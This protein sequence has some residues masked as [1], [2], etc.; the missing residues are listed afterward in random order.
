MIEHLTQNQ[1]EDYCLQ[2]LLPA[3]LLSVCDH[4]G[5]C[6]ACRRRIE[7]AINADA[8][9]FAL[10]SQVLGEAPEIAAPAFARLHPTAE[11]TAR[12]IEGSLAGEELQ[13][14]ADHLS[15]CDKCA[16]AVDDL[17]VFR[18]QIAFS[19]EREYLPASD[20]AP[21]E[22]W[23]RRMIA[24]LGTAFRG[25]PGLAF[26]AA[27]TVLLLAVTGWLIWR[28]LRDREQKQ[29]IIVTPTPSPSPTLPQLPEQPAP[30]PLVARLNDGEA[31]L[32]LDGEGKLSG[33]DDLPPAYQSLIKEALKSR[34]I[35]RSSELR[36]LNRPPSSLMG[37]DKERNE[38]SLIEPVGKVLTTDR[39]TFNWSQMEGATGYVVEIY[40]SRFNLVATS[41]QLAN[42]SWAMP[43]SLARDNVYTWQVKAIK[44]G[45]EF[46][47]PRPPAPQARF[48][49]LGQAKTIELAQAKRA[50]GSSHLTLGLLYADAGLIKEAEH[51]FRLLQKA[52]PDSEIARSL[53]SQVQALGR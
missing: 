13:T 51:E 6:D 9:F 46:T 48:R 49:I 4:L 35:V 5:E 24:S 30:A 3:D 2:K 22:G 29:E 28:T 36:G 25:S 10:R 50:Y 33:A 38:F 53:L 7:S 37:T 8:A 12:Y 41:L 20:H 16:M 23:W 21:T 47:S 14:V 27:L 26:G 44:D 45:H 39:P 15:G 18:E 52:N 19:L 17:R 32:T 1:V 34:R 31:Q 11:Q 43:Q 42:N 40:D